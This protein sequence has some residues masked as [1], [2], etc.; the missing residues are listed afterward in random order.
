MICQDCG[1]EI[2]DRAIVCFR[3]GRATSGPAP[4]LPAPGRRAGTQPLWL[5]VTALL[6][7]VAGGLYMATAA[8]GQVPAPLSYTIAALAA[9]VLAW[10][11]L[12]RK[13]R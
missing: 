5:A 2:S 10:R 4:A 9:V 11:V 7:L 12:R 6:V 8:S 1:T 13:R 3:C